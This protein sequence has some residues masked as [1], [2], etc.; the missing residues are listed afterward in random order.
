MK[1]GLMFFF[2]EPNPK[3]LREKKYVNFITEDLNSRAVEVLF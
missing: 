3:K 2:P 1:R